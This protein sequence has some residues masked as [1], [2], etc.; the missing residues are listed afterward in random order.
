MKIDSESDIYKDFKKSVPGFYKRI[1]SLGIPDIH[2]CSLHSRSGWV[3][4]K[5]LHSWPKKE[6]T[7]TDFG[8]EA[9]Q[10]IFLSGYAKY[11][12]AFL[13]V[14]IE[15]EYYLFSGKDAFTIR[16]G[17]ITKSQAKLMALTIQPG[18]KDLQ[19]F[20]NFT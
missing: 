17:G 18:D 19:W 11:G 2:Y 20:I 1:D 4:C 10:A 5:Y 9:E 14:W 8:I 15:E 16:M 6:K 3:E 12:K 7:T 13:L